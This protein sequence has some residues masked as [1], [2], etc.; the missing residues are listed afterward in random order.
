MALQL[1]LIALWA[2]PEEFRANA[3]QRLS[4]KRDAAPAWSIIAGRNSVARN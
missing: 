1:H 2:P 4:A 3:Y